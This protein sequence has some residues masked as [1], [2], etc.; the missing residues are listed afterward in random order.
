MTT[1]HRSARL[2][3]IAVAGLSVVACLGGTG[4]AAS[5]QP[6][7]ACPLS[8]KL[9]GPDVHFTASDGAGLVG[10][11]FGSGATAVVLAH[12][13]DG[14]LCAW[15]DEG[16]R[17]AAQGFSVLLFDFAGAG[18][19]AE[20]ANPS[21]KGLRLDLAAAVKQARLLG[22]K[23]VLLMGAS[24]GGWTVVAAAA[25]LRPQVQAVVA[26][27]APTEVDGTSALSA[28]H[29]LTIPVLYVASQHDPTVSAAE[30]RAIYAA[31]AAKTKQL[32]VVPGGFH[33]TTLVDLS[34]T[35]RTA[36]EQFLHRYGRR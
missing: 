24:L 3:A 6:A 11:R 14:S 34:K 22:A 26:V 31:T 5:V 15:V 25:D 16:R 2:L 8:G 29:R 28:V 19:S 20:R 33:G 4:R 18:A 32:V 9:A 7:Y 23:R 36:I 13:E 35:A 10:H 21:A 1:M 30:T 17:L 27:S 12:Q